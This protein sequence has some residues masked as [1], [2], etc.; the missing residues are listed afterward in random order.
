MTDPQELLDMLDIHSDYVAKL[1]ISYRRTLLA[2]LLDPEA[3]EGVP[4]TVRC[5][6]SWNAMA[7]RAH[8]ISSASI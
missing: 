7:T 2:G 6:G 5:W 8:R 1:Q 4:P 3:W